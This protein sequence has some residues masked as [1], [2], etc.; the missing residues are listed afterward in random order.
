MAMFGVG[1]WNNVSLYTKV[2]FKQKGQIGQFTIRE[3]LKHIV[4]NVGLPK[5]EIDI[6][7]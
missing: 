1:K 5:G 7:E 2:W 4:L 6:Q 3:A